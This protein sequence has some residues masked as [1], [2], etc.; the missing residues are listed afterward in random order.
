MSRIKRHKINSEVARPEKKDRNASKRKMW[1]IILGAI[2]VFSVFGIMLSSYTSE[3]DSAVYK[4]YK[5]ERTATGWVTEIA[6]KKASFYYLPEDLEK[7][8]IAPEIKSL[9]E[10]KV[11]YIT[12]N[13]AAKRIEQFELMRFE[14]SESMNSLFGIYSMPGITQESEQYTQPIVTCGNS[15]EMMPVIALSEA[16][17]TRAYTDGSCIVLEADAYSSNALKDRVL[18]SMLGILD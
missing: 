12:L 16:N 11:V 14:L 13:P 5:F 15:T 3:Q 10:S 6:G 1:T 4:G 2:M 18:Y 7:M 8:D 9:A 17:E